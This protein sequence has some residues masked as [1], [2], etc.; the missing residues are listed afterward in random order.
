MTLQ[1]SFCVEPTTYT[2]TFSITTSVGTL[3]GDVAGTILNVLGPP[4]MEFELGLSVLSGTGAFADAS[5]TLDVNIL[6]GSSVTGTV[7]VP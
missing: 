4:P 6:A 2:G 7:T 5:G 3:S 1:L